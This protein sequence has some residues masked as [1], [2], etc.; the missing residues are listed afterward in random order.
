MQSIDPN[1]AYY[2]TAEVVQISGGKWNR[3]MVQ[4]RVNDGM[5][6]RLKGTEETRI[7]YIDGDSVRRFFPVSVRKFT[8]N[9]T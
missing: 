9:D 4:R 3:R 8:P 2:T 6:Q 1:A 5:L 7:F